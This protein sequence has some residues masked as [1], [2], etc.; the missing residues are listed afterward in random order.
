MKVKTKQSLEAAWKALREENPKMR[1]RN[2]ANELNVSEAELLATKIGNTVTKLQP[3]FQ[4][5]LKDIESLGYVMALTRNNSVVHERKGVYQNPQFHGEVMGLFANDDIDLRIFFKSWKFA[6]ATQEEDNSNKTK[7]S[8]QFFASD[9]EAVHK[10][11]LTPKSNHK[12]FEQLV[13]KWQSETQGKAIEV[14]PWNEEKDDRSDEEVNQKAFQEAWRN[15]KDTHEFFGMLKKH[16][17]NRIQ[18]LRLAPKEFAQK[19]DNNVPRQILDIAS[20]NG[21]E[22]MVFVG[23]KGMIQIHTG[24]VKKVMEYGDWYNVLDPK[25]N[26]HLKEKDVTQAWVVKKPTKDGIVTAIECFDSEGNLIVQ[27]FGKRKPG[28]K[29]LELWRTSVAKIADF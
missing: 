23:N 3:K 24:T 19:V 29:E 10:I 4:S 13:N 20:V 26:L 9:G 18:A 11:F 6:F 2:A 17:V 7:K 27:F 21:V 25:F 16:K 15:L 5:I 8:I 28:I 14:T 1:I 12:A 22:I